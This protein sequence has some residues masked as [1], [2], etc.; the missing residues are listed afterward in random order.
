MAVRLAL[1]DV[2]GASLMERELE[3]RRDKMQKGENHERFAF[4][5]ETA[6]RLVK[7]FR[8]LGMPERAKP[9]EERLEEHNPVEYKQLLADL[10][11]QNATP[12]PPN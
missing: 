10:A 1:N 6:V 7:E 3:Q 4:P 9:Y 11:A 2:Q 8:R 12:Q 5:A